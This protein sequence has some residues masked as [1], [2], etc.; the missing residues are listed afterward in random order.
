M[1][2]SVHTEGKYV[3]TSIDNGEKKMTFGLSKMDALKLVQ[4]MTKAARMIK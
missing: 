2:I 3:Y 4:E 1:Q